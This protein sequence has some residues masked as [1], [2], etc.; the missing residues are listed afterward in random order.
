MAKGLAQHL[1]QAACCN[2]DC[3]KADYADLRTTA[4]HCELVCGN[5]CQNRDGDFAVLKFD[6]FDSHKTP[7]LNTE[8]Y[9]KQTV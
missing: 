4:R 1:S 9:D 2:L 5:P 7:S 8:V 6:L 3:Q